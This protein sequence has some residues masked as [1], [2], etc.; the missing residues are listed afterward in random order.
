MVNKGHRVGLPVWVYHKD[1]WAKNHPIFEGLPAG[2]IMDH[3]FYREVISNIGFTGQDVPA[4]VVVGSINTGC[5][6][7]SALMVG[8]YHLGAGRFTLNTL[9]IRE[10]LGNDPVA[11]RLLR[12]MLRD[13]TRDVAQPVAD[14]PVDFETQLKA[15]GY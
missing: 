11:E 15:M 3:T 4:E 7:H 2:C 13:A 9:R 12:N 10:N 6:Y 1:D 8:V 5:A 14:L